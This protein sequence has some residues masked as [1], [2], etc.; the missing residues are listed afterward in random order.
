MKT[1]TYIYLKSKVNELNRINDEISLIEWNKDDGPKFNSVEEMKEF[2]SK[3]NKNEFD[4]LIGTDKEESLPNN[5][6]IEKF[7][8]TVDDMFF[9]V[10]TFKRDNYYITYLDLKNLKENDMLNNL[11]GYKTNDKEK[12]HSYFEKI[13]ND[14]KT[15]NLNHILENMIMNVENNI[16][17]LKTKYD[18]LVS[19]S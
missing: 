16:K 18:K 2:I 9:F 17:I 19:A 8:Y 10:Y 15:D 13:T 14:L 1:N 12:S 3:V 11:Y 6:F 5:N 4:Y 7:D